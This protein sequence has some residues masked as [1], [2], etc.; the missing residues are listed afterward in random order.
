MTK[1]EAINILIKECDT[2]KISDGY[3]TFGELYEH[4]IRLFI[5]LCKFIDSTHNSGSKTDDKFKV[6]V[7][8][9]HYDNSFFDG[10]FIMGIG[11]ERGNQ[12]SYHLPIK[13][14]DEVLTFNILENSPEWDGHTSEDVLSRLKNL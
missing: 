2:N 14:W 5:T 9:K 7:S 3:H 10:W 4:R 1:E 8:K 6:W 11:T 13:Y 12:I